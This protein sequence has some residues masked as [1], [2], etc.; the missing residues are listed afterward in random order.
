V[1]DVEHDLALVH[2]DGEVLQLAAVGVAAPDAEPGVV[3][4][5]FPP[6]ASSAS[7]R[8]FDSSSRSNSAS[9]RPDLRVGC[10]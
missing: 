4:I 2:L 10:S 3:A 9:A 1:D 8:Y 7:V 6:R 5:S